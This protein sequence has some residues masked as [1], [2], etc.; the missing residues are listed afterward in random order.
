MNTIVYIVLYYNR[1]IILC[2]QIIF[3]KTENKENTLNL[4]VQYLEKCSSTA[5]QLA[6]RVWH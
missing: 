3:K 1:F 6:Y 5:Q 4:R 2:T